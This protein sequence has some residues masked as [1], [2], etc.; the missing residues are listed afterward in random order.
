MLTDIVPMIIPTPVF[1]S[2]KCNDIS[3]ANVRFFSRKCNPNPRKLMHRLKR[4]SRQFKK[5]VPA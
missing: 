3:R 2:R 4:R 5:G 1:N